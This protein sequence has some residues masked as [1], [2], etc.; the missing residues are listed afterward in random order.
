MSNPLDALRTNVVCL[1]QTDVWA[2]L[3]M[4][5]ATRALLAQAEVHGLGALGMRDYSAVTLPELAFQVDSLDARLS[6]LEYEVR[7]GRSRNE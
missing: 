2:D 4:D 6:L 7:D 3:P 1:E 5:A